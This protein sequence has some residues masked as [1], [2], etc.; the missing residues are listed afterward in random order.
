VFSWCGGCTCVVCVA[1]IRV[2]DVCVW[3]KRVS[4]VAGVCLVFARGWY[5]RYSSVCGCYAFCSSIGVSVARMLDM[6]LCV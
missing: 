2:V 3:R 6:V 4:F 5:A 1:G